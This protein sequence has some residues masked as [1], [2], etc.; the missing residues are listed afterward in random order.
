MTDVRVTVALHDTPSKTY[1]SKCSM[2]AKTVHIFILAPY[3]AGVEDC[4]D[5]MSKLVGTLIYPTYKHY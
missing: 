5:L 4:D 3:G 2:R 1:M